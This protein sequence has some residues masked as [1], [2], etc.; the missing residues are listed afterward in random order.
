[1]QLNRVNLHEA[2]LAWANEELGHANLGD[3]RRTNRLVR[4]VAQLMQAPNGCLNQSMSSSALLQGAYGLVESSRFKASAIGQ[5]AGLACARRAA[6]LPYVLVPVDATSLTFPGWVYREGLGSVGNHRYGRQGMHVMHAIGLTPMGTPLGLLAQRYWTRPFEPPEEHRQKRALKEK[7]TRH[8]LDV[9]EDVRAAFETA[10][11]AVRRWFQ[12]DRAADF[13]EMLEYASQSDDWLTVRASHD[14]KVQAP[15]EG[16]LWQVLSRQPCMGHM[17]VDVPLSRRR[18]ARRARL[19]VR[20]TTMTIVVKNRWTKTRWT[21]ELGAVLVREVHTTPRGEEPLEWLLW[22]NH[23]VKTKRDAVRVVNGY[24][25]RWKIEPFHR[26]WKTD[27]GVEEAQL[28]TGAAL[29]KWSYMTAVVAARIQ[30]LVHLAR[31]EPDRPA[32]DELDEHEVRAIVMLLKPKEYDPKTLP[33]MRQVVRWLAEYGGYAH[34]YSTTRH[35]GPTVV[36]RGLERIQS[37][38]ALLRQLDEK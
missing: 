27:V 34:L 24:A 11:M 23:P 18:R 7:E 14:R 15:L 13:R 17:Y 31:N 19:S 29:E 33:T 21:V 20:M 6:D 4:T 22:T 8:W 30:R 10:E 25:Q 1:M 5:A 35:P 26:I 2:A 32:S 12:C 28:Q 37:A 16:R 9:V 3:A 36:A 38:A